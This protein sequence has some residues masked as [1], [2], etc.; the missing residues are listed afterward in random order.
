MNEQPGYEVL[1][2]KLREFFAGTKDQKGIVNLKDVNT[3]ISELNLDNHQIDKI[4]EKLEANNIFY[5]FD[6]CPNLVR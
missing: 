1:E 6:D 4:Y 3:L 5:R 2:E